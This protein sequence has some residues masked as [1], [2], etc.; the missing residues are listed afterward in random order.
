MQ[1]ISEHDFWVELRGKKMIPISV[2][3]VLIHIYNIGKFEAVE[4]YRHRGDVIMGIKNTT[5]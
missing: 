2:Y 5:E 3:N 4:R 1:K